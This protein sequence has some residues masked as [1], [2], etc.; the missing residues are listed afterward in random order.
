MENLKT[1]LFAFVLFFSVSNLSA[2]LEIK[3]NP[4]NLLFN[5][6]DLSIEYAPHRNIGIELM[7]GTY[8]GNYLGPFGS[9]NINR[10]SGFKTRLTA[11][12]YLDPR[13]EA[14]GLYAG[15]YIGQRDFN[16]EE[17]IFG[18]DSSFFEQ[19]IGVV[20]GTKFIAD[21]GI[22]YELTVG[23]GKVVNDPDPEAVDAFARISVGYRF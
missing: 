11:K 19:A 21:Y 16:L 23:M 20:A 18:G 22:V 15:A 5:I 2:Q 6:P 10:Q 1:A 17:E 12:I 3:T 8:L 13:A 7:A 9:E 14:D 4:V